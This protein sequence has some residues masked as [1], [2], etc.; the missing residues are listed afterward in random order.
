MVNH[1][2]LRPQVV[3][4]AALPPS[5]A[6]RRWSDKALQRNTA[7]P[8]VPQVQQI[9]MVSHRAINLKVILT[10]H[11]KESM[12]QKV[13]WDLSK[14]K[15]KCPLNPILL[16]QILSQLIIHTVEWR[17]RKD[18]A[19]DRVLIANMAAQLRKCNNRHIII[20]ISLKIMVRTRV[21]PMTIILTNRWW[22]KRT[23][24]PLLQVWASLVN[25][26]LHPSK[27]S[28]QEWE[29]HNNITRT[30]WTHSYRLVMTVIKM[31]KW[32]RMCT[33]KIKPRQVTQVIMA[34][35]SRAHKINM[36]K[37][38]QVLVITDNSR[39]SKIHKTDSIIMTIL[40]VCRILLVITH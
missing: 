20:K 35:T 31:T 33:V 6:N 36:D 12:I 32:W 1:K 39:I 7:N 9:S 16:I 30:K 19:S 25:Q 37:G 2:L 14:F 13:Q 15:K 27:Q 38:V 4:V 34:I 3:P 5:M 11:I 29:V 17:L 23:K 22:E 8:V 24:E 28:T 40:K 18:L 26:E 21:I 10:H